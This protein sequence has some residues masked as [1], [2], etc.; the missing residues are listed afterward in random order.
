M[1][2]M[3][4]WSQVEACIQELGIPPRAPDPRNRPRTL[5]QIEVGRLTMPESVKRLGARG[6]MAVPADLE[7]LAQ[8]RIAAETGPQPLSAQQINGIR[9]AT[10]QQIAAQGIYVAEMGR[11]VAMIN[12]DIWLPDAA[13][14]GR[15][16]YSP[17]LTDPKER[18]PAAIAALESCSRST[19]RWDSRWSPISEHS[20]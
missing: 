14:L 12:Y 4:P 13:Q 9:A 8:W 5:A 19:G 15:V 2:I 17:A 7:F 1:R 3:G 16:I 6:R 18:S 11:P 10:Q 20:S